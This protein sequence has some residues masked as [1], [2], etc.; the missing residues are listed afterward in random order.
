MMSKINQNK[1]LKNAFDVFVKK[2]EQVTKL[3][4]QLFSDM[5]KSLEKK[6]KKIPARARKTSIK[7]K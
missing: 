7:K 1:E 2:M 3:Q 4:A 6:I 5:Q